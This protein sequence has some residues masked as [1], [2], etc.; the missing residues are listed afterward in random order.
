MRSSAPAD[1]VSLT[2]ART[3]AELEGSLGSLAHQPRFDIACD[4]EERGRA[5]FYDAAHQ[6]AYYLCG[7]D[8]DVLVWTWTPVE[9]WWEAAILRSL[10]EGLNE[11]LNEA[12]ALEFRSR[13]INRRPDWLI[14]PRQNR[15]ATTAANSFHAYVLLFRRHLRGRIGGHLV[16][17]V[18]PAGEAASGG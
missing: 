8:A 18:V 16:R 9:T 10:I 11:P 12:T 1:G 3:L 5:Y 17:P 4:L 7:Q 6:C 2:Q 14:A 13:A 15:R